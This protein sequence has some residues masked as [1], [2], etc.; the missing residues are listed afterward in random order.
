MTRLSLMGRKYGI[1]S[2]LDHRL[3]EVTLAGAGLAQRRKTFGPRLDDAAE[4]GRLGFGAEALERDDRRAA[5]G[6]LLDPGDDERPFE[7]VGEDLHP[8]AIHDDGMPGRDDLTHLRHQID[9]LREAKGD[10]LE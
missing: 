2:R 8:V 7:H 9:E 4:R 6:R 3:V 5:G 1:R 10:A